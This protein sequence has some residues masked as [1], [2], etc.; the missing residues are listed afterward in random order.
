MATIVVWNVSF[1]KSGCNMNFSAAVM[2]HQQAE[3]VAGLGSGYAFEGAAYSAYEIVKRPARQHCVVGQNDKYAQNR[4]RADMAPGFAATKRLCDGGYA[5]CRAAAAI[6]PDRQFGDQQRYANGECASE[7]NK[8]ECAATV[9]PHDIR[10]APYIA[11]TNTEA[12][13]GEQESRP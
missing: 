13:R 7:I 12:D 5:T 10:E 2:S 1:E 11:E 4:E 9:L 3:H 6:A 8:Q